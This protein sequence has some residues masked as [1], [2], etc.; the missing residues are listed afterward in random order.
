MRL[1]LLLVA[2]TTW[3]GL[4]RHANFRLPF[5]RRNSNAPPVSSEWQASP[6]KFVLRSTKD[7]PD[8]SF[9]CRL[10]KSGHQIEQCSLRINYGT[11]NFAI[12]VCRIAHRVP[13]WVLVNMKRYL[14]LSSHQYSTMNWIQCQVSVTIK[15]YQFQHISGQFS[16]QWNFGRHA[17]EALMTYVKHAWFSLQTVHQKRRK[18]W[19]MFYRCRLADLRDRKLRLIQ[20]QTEMSKPDS[21]QFYLFICIHIW[22]AFRPFGIPIS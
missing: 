20:T 9:V 6:Y 4:C 3:Q 12:S 7:A 10:N 17:Y 5:K 11:A 19:I 2:S 14:N 21:R 22:V 18:D 8:I 1:L 13:N 15:L 16:H